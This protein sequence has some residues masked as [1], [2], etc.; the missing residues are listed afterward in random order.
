ML[1]TW[2]GEY[3][4]AGYFGVFTASSVYDRDFPVAF[5]FTASWGGLLRFSS[6]AVNRLKI[7]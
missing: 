1:E 3:E 2:V 7:D 6:S 4:P 5:L